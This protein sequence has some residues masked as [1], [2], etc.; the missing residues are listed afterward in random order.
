M[1]K[2]NSKQDEIIKYYQE[3]FSNIS[4]D[5]PIDDKQLY[6]N[7]KSIISNIKQKFNIEALP[8]NIQK[9]MNKMNKYI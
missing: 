9:Y 8:S 3:E 5:S 4:Q 2:N 7:H 6:S 1:S